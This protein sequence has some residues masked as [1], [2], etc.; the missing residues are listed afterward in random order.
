M[1]LYAAACSAEEREKQFVRAGAAADRYPEDQPKHNLTG[2][3]SSIKR[4]AVG[5]RRGVDAGT[6][7]STI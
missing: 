2:G 5:C 4:S 7:R 6:R 3:P 1:R